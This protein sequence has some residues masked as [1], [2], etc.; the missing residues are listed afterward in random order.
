[1]ELNDF[2]LGDDPQAGEPEGNE[3]ETPTLDGLDDEARQAA[4]AYAAH[5]AEQARAT[6]RARADA[7]QQHAREYGFHLSED[8]MGMADA[9]LVQQKLSPFFPQPQQP[10]PVQTQAQQAPQPAEEPEPDQYDDPA[11]YL[12]WHID[13]AKREIRQEYAKE[14]ESVREENAQLA[15][16]LIGRQQNEAL[17]AV[18][19]AVKQYSPLMEPALQHPDFGAAYQQAVSNLPREQVWQLSNPRFVAQV[20]SYVAAGLDPARIPAPPPAVP[21][22]TQGRFSGR[23]QALAEIQRASMGRSASSRESGPATVSD[24]GP[25][26]SRQERHALEQIAPYTGGLDRRRWDAAAEDADGVPPDVATYN[27]RLAKQRR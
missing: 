15:S 3:P 24:R 6:E 27:A 8:G 9:H 16:H 7:Y 4:E 23:D 12:K 1:M 17:T 21:R 19:S 22:D 18:E 11:G 25:L 10:Q 20:A 2:D 13:R 14:I 26:I 5:L